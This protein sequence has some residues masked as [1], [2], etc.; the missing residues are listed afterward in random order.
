MKS[1]SSSIVYSCK[2]YITLIIVN[3]FVVNFSSSPFCIFN[4]HFK[5]TTCF[6]ALTINKQY[7]IDFFG[8]H[9]KFVIVNQ[10]KKNLTWLNYCFSQFNPISFLNSTFQIPVYKLSAKISLCN[11]ISEIT[12]RGISKC[13]VTRY[14]HDKI[15]IVRKWM[16][17]F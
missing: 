9:F 16:F 8:H 5:S 13:N 6:K 3:F 14:L 7:V 2:N 4:F 12:W 17:L 1:L 11:S 15:E 10:C